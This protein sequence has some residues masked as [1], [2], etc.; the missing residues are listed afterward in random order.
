ME[1][2]VVIKSL[3]NKNIQGPHGFRAELYQ[4]GKEKLIP[5]LLKLFYK[6][7]TERTLPNSFC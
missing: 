4:K 6:T 7:E 1:I 5:I 2:E 3:P